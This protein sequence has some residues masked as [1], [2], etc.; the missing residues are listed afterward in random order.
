MSSDFASVPSTL[1]PLRLHESILMEA[2]K[3][4]NGARRNAY[5]HPENNFGR[6]AALWQ[7]HLDNRQGGRAADLTTIDIALLMILMKVARLQ[8][9]PTHRDSAVD[10]AGYAATLEMLW[11]A[12]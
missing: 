9:T 1:P 12:P 6:I 5:G 3:I 10:I 11:D 2:E 4:V 8:E 7:V